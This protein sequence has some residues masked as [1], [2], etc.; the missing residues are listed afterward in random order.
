MRSLRTFK[1]G[2]E[3]YPGEEFGKRLT[4]GELK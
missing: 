2:G 3:S 4:N 1:V